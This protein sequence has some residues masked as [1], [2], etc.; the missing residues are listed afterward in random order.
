MREGKPQQQSR[1]LN[2]LQICSPSWICRRHNAPRDLNV[3]PKQLGMAFLQL[4]I[5]AFS[6]RVYFLLG[7]EHGVQK[8]SENISMNYRGKKNTQ[9]D[10][11]VCLIFYSNF[12]FQYILTSFW[13]TVIFRDLRN[14]AVTH[15]SNYNKYNNTYH[16]LK[17]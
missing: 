6:V 3:C 4:E 1:E 12:F 10:Q 13:P 16:L 15:Q 5:S 14:E 2:W 8:F 17:A 7:K 9:T 11:V